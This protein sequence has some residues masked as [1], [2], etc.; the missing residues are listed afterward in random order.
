MA[1]LTI[2]NKKPNRPSLISLL[3]KY[4][5]IESR[6]ERTLSNYFTGFTRDEMRE[7]FS[8]Y[9]YNPTDEELD[10]IMG[11]D[12]IEDN[13]IYVKSKSKKRNTIK[14]KVNVSSSSKSSKSRRTS[15][16]EAFIKFYP[17]IYDLSRYNRINS[18]YELDE[19]CTDNNIDIDSSTM[20]YIM[21]ND[22][23][24]CCAVPENPNSTKKK[25]LVD[26]NVGDL[27]WQ[28]AVYYT[29]SYVE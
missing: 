19:Y 23:F 1:I 22:S 8:F 2:I 14:H 28:A 26:S 29:N 9:G 4:K 20:S 24:C 17:D 3:T 25:L 5:E 21:N 10:E 15:I 27:R 6:N 18:Y 12:T 7:Y 16:D 13:D 11:K